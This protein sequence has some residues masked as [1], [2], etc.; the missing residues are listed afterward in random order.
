MRRWFPKLFAVFLVAVVFGTGGYLLWRDTR[1]KPKAE[2]YTIVLPAGVNIL[3]QKP[4]IPPKSALAH[5]KDWSK[6]DTDNGFAFYAPFATGHE[7]LR[8][9]DSAVG[10]IVNPRF[11]LEYDF[12]FYSPTYEDMRKAP[13]YSEDTIRI[14]G[15][16]AVIRRA[17]MRDPGT[18]WRYWVALY[19]PRATWV[20]E[21][22]LNGKWTALVVSGW[23]VSEADRKTVEQMFA[24]ITF[25]RPLPAEPFPK[26]GTIREQ[27]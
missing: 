21:M 15:R 20:W 19:V 6:F 24:T 14:D 18:G 7:R 22:D 23:A 27:R 10:R 2:S 17:K 12:G 3:Q 9:I 5:P 8:G 11:R 1:P 16:V 13:D 26:T 4:V 25:D